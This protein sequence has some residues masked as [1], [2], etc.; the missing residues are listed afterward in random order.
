MASY[1]GNYYT[2]SL[3]FQFGTGFKKAL[4]ISKGGYITCYFDREDRKSYAQ[5]VIKKF[6]T[7]LL[8][9]ENFCHI[10][11][12]EVDDLVALTEKLLN[13]NEIESKDFYKFID[14]FSAYNGYFLPKEKAKQ[15]LPLLQEAR[16]YTEKVHGIADKYFEKVGRKIL[17]KNKNTEHLEGGFIK[18]DF[19]AFFANGK[20]PDLNILKDRLNGTAIEF[21]SDE[22]RSYLGSDLEKI[23]TLLQPKQIE[24]QLSGQGAYPGKVRG[25]IKII[26][27]PSKTAGFSQ[28][29]ILVSSMTRPEYL[30]LMKLAGAVV[31]DAGGL[32]CHAAIA[33][34]ELKIPTVIGTEVATKTL[35]DGDLVEVDADK[36]IVKIL[37]K[38]E[39]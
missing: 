19:D 17:G 5:T 18:D 2:K 20:V 37:K 6:A 38:N 33:A 1:L 8:S 27:D 23:E 30:P 39:Q 32:L 21:T 29:Q 26:F 25:T 12:K 7:S 13:K 11:K 14:K 34:R 31:T 24:G 3:P 35:K 9:I 36:G 16:V 28:G 22:Y 4:I 10:L 15:Y